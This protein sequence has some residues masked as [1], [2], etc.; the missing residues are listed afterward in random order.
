MSTEPI[1]SGESKIMGNTLVEVGFAQEYQEAIISSSVLEF[2]KEE[3]KNKILGADKK[4]LLIITSTIN[5]PKVIDSVEFYNEAFL[6]TA[7]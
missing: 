5:S 6:M 2:K 3:L 7:L 4:Q 1:I